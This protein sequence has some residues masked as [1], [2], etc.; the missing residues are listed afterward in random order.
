M[1]VP[2][3]RTAIA[4]VL[5]VGAVGWL[6]AGVLPALVRQWAN[7]D[8]YSHGFFVVPLALFFAW[9]RRAALLSASRRPSHS[10]LLLL[11]GSLLCFIAGQFGSELFLTRISMIGVLA[12]MVLFVLGW[13]HLKLLAFPLAFL[14]LM[15]PLP[16]ILFNQIAFPL[17]LLASRMGEVAIA[18]SGVPVLREGNV[19]FL[20]GRTLEVAEA[21][22][23]IR[24]LMTLVT[25]AIVLGYFMERRTSVRLLIVLA[26]IPIA[27]IANATR[28][29]GTG[30]TSYW[31]SPAAAEGFFHTFSGWIMFIV[32]LAGLLAFQ[33]V[34]DMTRARWS[35]VPEATC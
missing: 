34:L 21:C 15:V 3:P 30:L 9:E 22:S 12:G 2:S 24:S 23:G 5:L 35:R 32:A 20:P 19:L 10:G 26:A 11:A 31:I 16:A 27:V 6:Y 14:L 29:A 7:D 8:D 17:Q 33:R 18:A 4:T 1:R 28:V 13:Q 25:L